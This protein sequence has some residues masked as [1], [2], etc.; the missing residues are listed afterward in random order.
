MELQLSPDEAA[1]Q[2]EVRDIISDL[3]RTTFAPHRR[4]GSAA[5]D[6]AWDVRVEWDKALAARGLL[7]LSWPKEVGGQGRSLMCEVILAYECARLGAPYRAAAL[8]LDLFG[9][10]LLR[11]GTQEQKLRFLPSILKSEEYWGQGFSETEAGSDLASVRTRAVLDG[12][13]WVI[14]GHKIWMTIGARAQWFYVL[15][16]TD[17]PETRHRGLTM[18]MI[19]AAQAGIEVRPIKNMAGSE[20]FC[21]VYFSDAVTARDLVLGEINGGWAVALTTLEIE[22]GGALLGQHLSFG[23][24]V[25]DAVTIARKMGRTS[26][27]RIRDRLVEAWVGAQLIRANAVRMMKATQMGGDDVAALSSVGK[28]NAA[29]FH[30]QLGELQMD[31]GGPSSMMLK[32]DGMPSLVQT[33][34]LESF[35]ESIYGGT[36]EIQ[37][38]I[39]AERV[40]GMPR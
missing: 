30:Q 19:P 31:I 11:H 28:I 6:L 22:R 7:G 14:N 33:A 4:A 10:L 37:K 17:A 9:P 39:L 15:C 1:F 21:E 32:D 13:Q 35:S 3:L 25:D 18:L 40:L 26:D 27:V 2:L 5:N 24:E 38:N 29:R 23:I 36:S 34:Y 20:D 16:R 8:T 12:D